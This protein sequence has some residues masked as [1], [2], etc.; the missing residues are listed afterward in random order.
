MPDT[1]ANDVDIAQQTIMEVMKDLHLPAPPWRFNY[2]VSRALPHLD[3]R[4]VDGL[5]DI[6]LR[7][8]HDNDQRV[9]ADEQ[10]GF[11]LD[12]TNPRFWSPQAEYRV[13][14][15]LYAEA[16]TVQAKISIK[17]RDLHDRET[18]R[19]IWPFATGYTR[20]AAW[21]ELRQDYRQFLHKGIIHARR[22]DET[23]P[24]IRGRHYEDWLTAHNE[25]MED[26]YYSDDGC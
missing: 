13:L 15:E 26:G 5:I 4:Q 22:L 21:C 12:I 20:I 16:M 23:Y 19:V 17:Y 14:R 6:A 18:S 7:N 1:Q 10:C 25:R 11:W 3:K 2:P 8:L 9:K 24:G